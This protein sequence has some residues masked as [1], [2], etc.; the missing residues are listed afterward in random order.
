MLL[1]DMLALQ[2]LGATKVLL[3]RLQSNMAAGP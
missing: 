2:P 1:I 3:Q